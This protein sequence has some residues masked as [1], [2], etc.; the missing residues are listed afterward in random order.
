MLII[1]NSFIIGSAHVDEHGPP[2]D[3]GLTILDN[4]IITSE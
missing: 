3:E 1:I 4:E 2:S